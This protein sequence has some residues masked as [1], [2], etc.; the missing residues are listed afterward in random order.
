MKAIRDERMD[1][2]EGLAV[3]AIK[4]VRAFFAYQGNEPRYFQK[5]RLGIGAIGAYGRLRAS[6]TNRMA[7]EAMSSRQLAAADR[8]AL[9]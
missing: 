2:F 8:K 1:D 5:A 4:Q 6:E 7:I 3:E 9:R